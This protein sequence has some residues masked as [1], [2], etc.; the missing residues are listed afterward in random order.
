LQDLPASALAAPLRYT[1]PPASVTALEI[2]LA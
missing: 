1:F 2:T